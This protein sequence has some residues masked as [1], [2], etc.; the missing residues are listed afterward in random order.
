[1]RRV[2]R[3]S[4]EGWAGGNRF[5][6]LYLYALYSNS[7]KDKAIKSKERELKHTVATLFC[8][9]EV[10]SLLLACKKFTCQVDRP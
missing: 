5:T 6:C 7:L 3:R 8:S 9:R 1:M 10:L 2:M 4:E